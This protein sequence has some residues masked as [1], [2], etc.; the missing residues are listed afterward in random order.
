MN[1][2]ALNRLTPAQQVL[3][4]PCR[5]GGSCAAVVGRSCSGRVRVCQ[6]R[7][8]KL[9][10]FRSQ[11]AFEHLGWKWHTGVPCPRCHVGVD[12]YCLQL[13]EYDTAPAH[14]ARVEVSVREAARLVNNYREAL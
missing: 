7:W 1:L 11:L 10:Q 13:H 2:A 8:E 12:E 9:R 5:G 3:Q 4:V 14:N 6:A